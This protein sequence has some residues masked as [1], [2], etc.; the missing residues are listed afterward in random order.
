MALYGVS[1][2]TSMW[3]WH[4]RHLI[5]P[6]VVGRY[7]GAE[8]VGYVALTI[9][10]VENLAFVKDAA[11]RISLAALGRLQN[12]RKKFMQTINE[13]VELQILMLG[14][15]FLGFMLGAQLFGHSIF[16]KYWSNVS[17]LYPFIALGYLVNA[18]F[19]LFSSALYVLNYNWKVTYFH[20]T[21]VLLF[22]STSFF[23]VNRFGLIGYGL[24]E[25]AAVFSYPVMHF[26]FSKYVGRID[27]SMPRIWC[28]ALSMALFWKYFGVIS[29]IPLIMT[30]IWPKTMRS[31]K[32]YGG[33]L[34][35]IINEK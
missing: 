8:G 20:L 6:F 3:V 1:F 25:I 13:G 32:K 16:G 21:H 2:T 29:F 18:Y 35:T 27:Q 14:P 7:L 19:S 12:N 4:L 31:L 30:L 9:K 10:I 11:W 5:N 24:G 23:M 26:L 17:A 28:I 34:R 15:I 22:I 33:Y